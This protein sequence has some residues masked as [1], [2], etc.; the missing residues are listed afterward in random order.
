MELIPAL[1]LIGGSVVRLRQGDYDQVTNYGDPVELAMQLNRDGATRIHLVDLDA[2]KSGAPTNH[3]VIADIAAAVSMPVQCGGGVRSLADV[4]RLIGQGV[5][6]VIVGTIALEE[7]ELAHSM[8][9]AFPH[10]VLLGLDYRIVD[11][12]LVPAGRGWLTD[13]PTTVEELLLTY[14]TS[15]FAGVLA[16]AIARDGTLEGPDIESMKRLLACSPIPVV[17]SGGVGTLQDL[18]TLAYLAATSTL[19]SGV[20]VGKAL[21]EGRFTVAEGVAACAHLG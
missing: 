19:L 2:A 1:D 8:A 5:N 13:S 11:D 4:E 9:Q 20:V 21:L 17:A 3:G 16:T 10:Q 12:R 18:R 7:P 14:A 6:R 15:P